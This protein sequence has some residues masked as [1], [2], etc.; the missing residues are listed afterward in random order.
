M[1]LAIAEQIEILEDEWLGCYRSGWLGLLV[2]EAFAHPAKVARGLASRIYEH[3]IDEGWIAEGGHVVD[4]FGGIAGC[5]FHA[6]THGL[7]WTGCELEEKFVALGNQNIALW[8][9]PYSRMPKWGTARLLQGDSRKLASVIREAA[10]CV[11]SRPYAAI[12]IDRNR[13]DEPAWERQKHFKQGKTQNKNCVGS[14]GLSKGQLGA[15]KEGDLS[16]AI[17]SPPYSESLKP[18]TP[19]QT[20][21]KQERIARSKTLYDGR[22][23]EQPSAGKAG[24]GGGYGI[25]EGNVAAMREGDHADAC[26]SSPPFPQPYTSGGGINQCGLD[27]TDGRPNDPIGER[28]YQS[29]GGERSEGNLETMDAEGFQTAISSPPFESSQHC[30]Q[31]SGVAEQ[32]RKGRSS[33]GNDFAGVDNLSNQ[34]GDTFWS[35]SRTIL[36]QLHQVLTPDAHAVFVVKAFVRNKQIVDFPMQWAQLCEA[37][38]FK[39]IH[40]HRAL[41]TETYGTQQGFNGEDITHTIE[42]KS[43][44]RR[45]AESKG[46]PRI[47][48]ESVLCFEKRND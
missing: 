7:N 8:N 4:P 27:R 47:D 15:M 9:D 5:G 37:V 10:C 46:S 26:I 2:P 31:S 16:L 40:H 34:R 32:A 30:N 11:S 20:A 6:M 3:V 12:E 1:S 36:E 21:A 41:L 43:F 33:G 13:H 29:K 35:A 18:E 48:H 17:S 23:L 42:R 25:T 44:F 24:L 28:T 19:D 22:K 38:G 39:L 14:Y 45:L